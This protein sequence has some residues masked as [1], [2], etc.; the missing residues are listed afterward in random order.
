MLPPWRAQRM[1]NEQAYRV[2][3]L[4]ADGSLKAGNR[5]NNPV[6]MDVL[7]PMTRRADGDGQNVL[8]PDATMKLREH[9]GEGV[10]SISDVHVS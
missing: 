2:R 1:R 6:G 7:E 5:P 3:R 9:S 4:A 10:G 8:A